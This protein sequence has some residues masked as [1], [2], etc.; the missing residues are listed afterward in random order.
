M[1]HFLIQKFKS[2]Q[3]LNQ[4]SSGKGISEE[5]QKLTLNSDLKANLA[6][7]RSLLGESY[8][9]VI[10][11]FNF[12]SEKQYEAALIY[13]KSLTDKAIIN[14]SVIKP[15]MYD[16]RFIAEPKDESLNMLEMS[17]SLLAVEEVT[18]SS[19]PQEI[20][21]RFMSGYSILLVNGINKVLLINTS[22]GPTRSID[23]P[24]TETVV[25]GPR[26]G[27]TESLL[28]NTTLLRR[29]IK[30]I[31]LSFETMIL[32]DQTR[33]TICIAYIKGI[34]N[35]QL[36]Q[37]IKRRLKLIKTDAILESGYIEQFIEDAPFSIFSTIAN[38]EKP[39][40][41]AAE[42]LE[43]RAAIFVEGTPFVLTV[44]M[45]FIESFQNA[46]DYYS[47]PYY[48]T[49][50]RLMRLLSYFISILAPAIYVALTTF[51]QELIPTPLLLTMA[52]AEEGVPFPAVIEA[53]TMGIIYEI[54]RE[55]GI[56]L[57]RP[58]GQ[59]ISIV[60][61][62]VIGETAVQAGIVGEPMVILVSLTA[63]AS[64]VV[65]PQIDSGSILRLILVI[66]AGFMGGYGIML[67]L[68]G[69]LIHLSSLRSFGVPYLSPIAPI[70]TADLKD[71][72][73]RVPLWAMLAR[74]YS[75]SHHDPQRQDFRLSLSPE[76]P[77]D[78]SV[79]NK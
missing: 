1:L 58:V 70:N 31:N 76:E 67:G 71:T 49:L 36:I 51:H 17:K 72:F 27:F 41:V 9:I 33:T 14:D 46:E 26:E 28:T 34:V 23:E 12:G 66:L 32:G 65:P 68:L 53:L 20:L 16:S 25:R 74:P 54:L 79:K 40:T 15:L 30:N 55:A 29:K 69:V 5:Y 43:G 45:L 7:F 38:N 75:L 13:L 44:P 48:A 56:R 21:D 47:R 37:E 3:L 61:A 4:N 10:R 62:L 24:K 50:I 57:P 8:D 35:P 64:F 77:N 18:E 59:A 39:D 73:V 6:L 19:S 11:E 60:G 52:Q 2:Y 22:G 63:V 42:I 78:N